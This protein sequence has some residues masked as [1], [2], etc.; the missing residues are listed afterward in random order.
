MKP[1]KIQTPVL[2]R[3]HSDAHKGDAGRLLVVAGATGTSGAARLAARGALGAGVGLLTVA[4][5]EPIRSE[6][7][8][9]DAAYMT[10][11]LTSTL[12]GSVAYPAARDILFRAANAHAVAIGPGLGTH[13]ETVACVR[14]LVA[15]LPRPTVVD[16]DALN[17]LVNGPLPA[18]AAPRVWTPHP[19]EAAR[20]LGVDPAAVVHDRESAVRALWSRLGGIV[21]LKGAGTLVT[22]G[23]VVLQ[24]P[25]GNPGL[26]TG[27]SG[28]VL[29]GM[30]GAF[31]AGGLE[32][33]TAACAAVYIH[34]QAAD[35]LSE[36]AGQRGLSMRALL[37]VLPRI[38][39]RHEAAA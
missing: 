36:S 11:G 31:L 15:E 14:R 4:V 6:V 39:A 35:E 25:T 24:N 8:A 32:P 2:P 18:V 33:L 1:D 38:V 20:L 27:G 7:A 19:G 26:A 29:T 34:G 37:D 30:I 16:A 22:D 3:R 10:A 28:D 13:E 17:A 21:V 23:T 9:G 5:P 12:P